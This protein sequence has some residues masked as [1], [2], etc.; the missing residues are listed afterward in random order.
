VLKMLYKRRKRNG[1]FVSRLSDKELAA[2]QRKK[3][4]FMY[5][6]TLMF[7]VSLFLQVEGRTRLSDNKQLFA[8]FSLY[9]IAL[10]VLIVLTV[11]ISVMNRTRHKIGREIRECDTPRTGLDRRTFTSYELFNALHLLIAAAEVAGSVYE[12]GI[13]G[14]FNI[15]VSVAS[16]VLCF[17][18][19]QILFKAN[20][21]NLDFVEGKDE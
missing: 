6:S 20:S 15:I 3:S 16:A 18:S 10:L 7:A 5:L 12:I 9:V 17:I 13:W 2:L 14:V 8:L 11:F 21:N 4:L 19:R 1:K